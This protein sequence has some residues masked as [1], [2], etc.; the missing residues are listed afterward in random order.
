MRRSR[1][2]NNENF[3]L[4]SGKNL[5]PLWRPHIAGLLEQWRLLRVE[6]FPAPLLRGTSLAQKPSGAQ[7]LHGMWGMVDTILQVV[8][9]GNS[10]GPLLICLRCFT[11]CNQAIVYSYIFLCIL[12]VFNI[13]RACDFHCTS[14]A[15][16]LELG[17]LKKWPTSHRKREYMKQCIGHLP[18]SFSAWSKSCSSSA[19]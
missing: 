12:Y 11:I 15:S 13:Y 17:L 10:G 1:K 14:E 3:I 5:R 18:S 9:C 7:A 2:Q 8:I 6:C 4:Q 19:Y 16:V